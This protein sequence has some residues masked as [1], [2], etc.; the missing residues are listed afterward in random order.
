VQN[1]DD[2]YAD[3]LK[4]LREGTID[5]VV[6][7]IYWHIGHPV[8]DY[9]TLVE[10]WN[11]NSYGKNL[12]IGMGVYKM[13]DRN[14]V[15]A[16]NNGNE[17]V[18][19]LEL[20]KN[21]PKVDGVMYFNTRSYLRNIAGLNDSLQNNFYRY[22]ALVPVNRNIEGKAAAVPQNARILSDGNNSLLFWDKI[23]QRIGDELA[24][25]VVYAF[26]GRGVGDMNNPANILARTHDNYLDL[27]SFNLSGDY[28]FVVS[29]INRYHHESVPT[30]AVTRRL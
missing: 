19:Q 30:Y 28:T 22:P 4:W 29:S 5:Y 12:Y 8:A 26:P 9:K 10:W 16:W 24:Y 7:Q 15:A 3:I 25:Y 18:R 2:L 6:P 11:D 17:I 1:Y 13:G 20:N 21:Y 14:E 27:K 23:E